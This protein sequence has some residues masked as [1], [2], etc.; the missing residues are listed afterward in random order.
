VTDH[1]EIPTNKPGALDSREES[2]HL[3]NKVGG[4]GVVGRGVDVG[5]RDDKVEGD[6]GENS[7]EG[8]DVSGGGNKRERRRVPSSDD[9]PTAAVSVSRR[10]IGQTGREEGQ[11]FARVEGGEFGLLDAGDRRVR[12]TNGI[13]NNVTLPRIPKTLGIPMRTSMFLKAQSMTTKH[14][15]ENKTEKDM[16][17]QQR[18]HIHGA[19]TRRGLK[20]TTRGTG[21]DAANRSR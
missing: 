2:E 8:E 1:V 5:D 14:T 4:E 9:A 6:G 21:R 3:E 20:E 18:R 15:V 17:I 12:R 16:G 13:A 7:G 11:E 10:K 19:T